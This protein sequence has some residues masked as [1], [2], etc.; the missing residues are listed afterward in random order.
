M[1]PT[2]TI[3]A[4]LS[5]AI[6]AR[7]PGALEDAVYAAFEAGLPTELV[8]VLASALLLPWHFRHEDIATALHRIKDPRAVTSLGR[9]ALATHPYLAYDDQCGLARKC[10]A[11]LVAVGNAEAKSQLEQLAT[12]DNDTCASLAR[13]RL[14]AWEREPRRKSTAHR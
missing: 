1:R 12:S 2:E 7:D 13:K 5:A 14:D 9:A 3:R 11:A 4:E 6:G 10:I 8:D